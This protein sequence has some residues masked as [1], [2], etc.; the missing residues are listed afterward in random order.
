[1]LYHYDD[2]VSAAYRK[3]AHILMNI[4]LVSDICEVLLSDM[5]VY[6]NK[7]DLSIAELSRHQKSAYMYSRNNPNNRKIAELS[8]AMRE[9]KIPDAIRPFTRKLGHNYTVEDDAFFKRVPELVLES[10]GKIAV[11]D[12]IQSVLGIHNHANLMDPKHHISILPSL[13]DIFTFLN[14]DGFYPMHL[15]SDVDVVRILAD[16]E[17][18]EMVVFDVDESKEST[19]VMRRRVSIHGDY[20]RVPRFGLYARPKS[21]LDEWR[22]KITMGMALMT[23][24]Y[25][26]A[27]DD[28]FQSQGSKIGSDALS[29]ILAKACPDIGLTIDDF[30]M[31][32]TTSNFRNNKDE[33]H[34]PFIEV[35]RTFGPVLAN[36]YLRCDKYRF[37][38]MDFAGLDVERAYKARDI[39]NRWEEI[40]EACAKYAVIDPDDIWSPLN[41]AYWMYDTTYLN[42][43][44]ID[45]MSVGIEASLSSGKVTEPGRIRASALTMGSWA[46]WFLKY[47]QYGSD[48]FKDYL[49]SIKE[50]FNP[51][52][53]KDYALRSY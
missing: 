45:M 19:R 39:M 37:N 43:V 13:E 14:T 4:P 9:A 32:Q 3:Y 27:E 2:N 7:G 1:M 51:S 47:P 29:C 11:D 44:V 38:L 28:S 16:D 23:A 15:L 12:V 36:T 26:F 41:A 21:G 24:K 22:D 52:C 20:T 25:S 49:I 5:L 42:A 48:M 31:L 6:D 33:V 17:S 34:Q 53:T 18:W 40:V 50:H 10:F 8:T 46:Q 35:L 30:N